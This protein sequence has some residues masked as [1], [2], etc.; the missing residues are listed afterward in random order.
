MKIIVHVGPDKTG[1]SFIQNWCNLNRELLLHKKIYYPEHAVDVNGISSGNGHLILS[2]NGDVSSFSELKL[3]KLIDVANYEKCEFLLI[4]GE[5]LWQFMKNLHTFSSDVKLI[6]YLRLSCDYEES[7]YNQCVKRHGV[8]RRFA[9]NSVGH[10]FFN[11]DF[12]Q[13][14]LSQFVLR[15]YMKE[16]F[17]RGDIVSDFLFS[18]GLWDDSFEIKLSP[19]VNS[20][21]SFEAL[22]FKR[23][24]NRNFK[25]AYQDSKK[26]DQILQA[27]PFGNY[28]YSLISHE[29]A[30][31]INN[32]LINKFEESAR[33]IAYD[34]SGFDE[35]KSYLLARKFKKYL[36]QKLE[37]KDFFNIMSYLQ[38]KNSSLYESIFLRML[39]IDINKYFLTDTINND[40]YNISTYK[41]MLSS[42]TLVYGSKAITADLMRDLALIFES[43]NR[44][45]AIDLMLLAGKM[46]PNG[47]FIKRKIDEYLLEKTGS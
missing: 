35:Y 21:Y 42:I 34:F 44:D 47:P 2:R 41:E 8:Y 16:M 12:N 11:V 26:I 13:I 22:E 23:F 31:S 20:S 38:N 4:S 24:L 9:I 15:Y 1:T 43:N 33:G 6:F 27:Y 10:R 14:N 32:S 45:V 46:R 17:Y 37:K 30:F 39:D 7:S 25:M 29:D 5:N 18:A 19:V 40:L 3:Q 28:D 36:E